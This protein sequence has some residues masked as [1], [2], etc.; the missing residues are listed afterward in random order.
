LDEQG[1]PWVLELNAIPGLTE[2]S[3]A[4]QAARSAGWSMQQLCDH[5]V[6]ECL[7]EFSVR[8]SRHDPISAAA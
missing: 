5:L 1:E 7:D 4:P 6:R 8:Q 3:L 2:S